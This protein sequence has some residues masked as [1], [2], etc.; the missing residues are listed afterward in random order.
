MKTFKVDFKRRN[1]SHLTRDQVLEAVVPLVLGE[2]NGGGSEKSDAPKQKY[3]VDLS[4]PDFSIRIEVCKTF[5]G[6][7]ILPR[8]KW[9]KNFNLAELCGPT[10]KKS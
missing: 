4:D 10:S 6:V 1:C 8:Q 3:A 2:N 7:S 9:C 5:C